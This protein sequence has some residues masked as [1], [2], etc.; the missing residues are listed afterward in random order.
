MKAAVGDKVVIRGH[1]VT[2][3]LRTG[4]ILEVRGDDGGPPFIVRWDDDAAEHEHLYFPGPD[5]DIEPAGG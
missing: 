1:Q 4:V 5:A 3:T 2:G